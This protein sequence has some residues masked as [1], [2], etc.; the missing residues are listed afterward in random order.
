MMKL[1]PGL[2]RFP[3]RTICLEQYLLPPFVQW[4][5]T[6]GFHL[7]F[8]CGV[9][10]NAQRV[11]IYLPIHHVVEKRFSPA[12]LNLLNQRAEVTRLILVRFGY[13]KRHKTTVIAFDSDRPFFIARDDEVQ[14]AWFFA[15]R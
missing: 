12:V 3:R 11:F 6:R 7:A 4:F 8:R 5:Q 14:A 1:L 13:I 10:R 9:W 2:P 15:N